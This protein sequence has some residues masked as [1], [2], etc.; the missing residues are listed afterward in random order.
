[1]VFRGLISFGVG[2][3]FLL[4]ALTEIFGNAQSLTT[5]YNPYPLLLQSVL[6]GFVSFVLI[7]FG[8]FLIVKDAKQEDH[9]QAPPQQ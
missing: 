2:G 7:G 3:A 8:L 4:L 9:T 6:L 1:M 5:Y